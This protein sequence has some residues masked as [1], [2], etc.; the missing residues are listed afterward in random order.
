MHFRPRRH[1]GSVSSQL[2]RHRTVRRFTL[3]GLVVLA[4]SAV[5]DRTGAF[6]Y[7]G[8]DWRAFDHKSFV[9]THVADGDTINVRPSAGGSETRVRLLG[10]DTPELHSQSHPG[11]D[12]W[13]REAMRYTASRV[14]GRAV[15]LR[16]EPTKTRDKYRRLLAYVY[17]GDADI[18][19]LDLV[20]DG[21]AYADRRFP[22]SLRSQFEQAEG[23]ARKKARGLWKDVTESQMPPWRQEWLR[24]RQ[25]DAW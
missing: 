2:R 3:A 10:V 7:D 20:R 25:R 9:V 19:N 15:T 11:A 22:H 1:H 12:Y 14:E 13:A 17:L 24:R 4:L 18:F 6:R 8:D 16:L 5:L 21:E 23:E